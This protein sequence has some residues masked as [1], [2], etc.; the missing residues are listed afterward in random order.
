MSKNK[1]DALGDRMKAYEAVPKN[2]LMR[3]TPVVIRIDGK[4]FHS[5]TKGFAKPVDPCIKAAMTETMK[6]LC[7]NIQGCVLGYTQ[8]DEITLVLCDYQTL[9]TDAWFGYNVQKLC[10]VAAS[11]ATY[12]FIYEFNA[13]AW[14]NSNW[15]SLSISKEASMVQKM[16]KGIFFDARCFNISKEEVANCLIWRQKD[17]IRNSI[18]GLAQVHFPH[19]EI[20]GLNCNQLIEK[21]QTEKNINWTDCDTYQKSGVCAIKKPI[22][23]IGMSV[24]EPDLYWVIDWNTP[25]FTENRNYINGRITFEED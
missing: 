6:Y 11:M 9:E 13:M 24:G 8:S 18:Q 3:R 4:S 2:F 7:E 14:K 5:V 25:I 16:K 15:T 23:T 10:S 20:Q 19:K 21:L 12:R 17:A 22:Y 1:K